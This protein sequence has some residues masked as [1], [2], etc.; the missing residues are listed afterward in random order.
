MNNRVKIGVGVLVL[1]LA[2]G[3][4][5]TYQQMTKT[6]KDQANVP[7]YSPSASQAQGTSGKTTTSAKATASTKPSAA[8][9][10]AGCST[11]LKEMDDPKKFQ[12]EKMKVNSPMMSLGE[13]EDG[14]AAAPPKNE[15]YSV[16]WWKNG[17]KVGSK[18]GHAVLTIHT[19]RSGGA[20]GNDLYDQKKGLKPGDVIKMSDDQGNVQCYKMERLLKVYVKDYDPNSDI[21]YKNDGAPQA[22][23]VICWDFNWGTEDW[24]SRILYYLTPM[25]A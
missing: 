4:F 2:I 25:A 24:D 18:Q 3:G 6:N 16:G 11:T 9:V 12:I 1:L 17:P 7:V 15:G 22:V 8:K 21:L 5:I 23:I 10:P 13:D 14:A 19:Y 20:L